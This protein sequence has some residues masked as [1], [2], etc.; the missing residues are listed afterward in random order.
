MKYGVTMIPTDGNFSGM[1]LAVQRNYAFP[2]EFDSYEAAEAYVAKSWPSPYRE[3]FLIKIEPLAKCLALIAHV[4]EVFSG[5]QQIELRDGRKEF[6]VVRP[7]RHTYEQLRDAYL[8]SEESR[9]KWTAYMQEHRRIK[10][11]RRLGA[12]IKKDRSQQP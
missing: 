2:M 12:V 5:R 3:Q 6:V 10:E 4:V 9:E 11:R 8:L 7:E 1:R